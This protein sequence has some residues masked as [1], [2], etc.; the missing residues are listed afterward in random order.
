MTILKGWLYEHRY[1]AYPTD[2]EKLEL[3]QQANLTVLQV[4]NWFINARRR[5][6]P[7]IIKREGNDP[8]Q[9]TITR[10]NKGGR[11]DSPSHTAYPTIPQLNSGLYQNSPSHDSTGQS[12]PTPDLDYSE[13]ETEYYEGLSDGFESEGSSESTSEV[14]VSF[15]SDQLTVKSTKNPQKSPAKST[16]PCNNNNNNNTNNN[17]NSDPNLLNCFQILVDIA[18]KQLQEMEQDS[19]VLNQKPNSLNSS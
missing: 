6:L 7:E 14:Q 17:N 15:L 12:P 4:C 5:I 13:P 9:Y 2:Q 8:M 11:I 19:H 16:V 10:K 3:A 1:N 18:V